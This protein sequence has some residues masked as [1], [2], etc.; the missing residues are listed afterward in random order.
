MTGSNQD[1]SQTHLLKETDLR[2]EDSIQRSYK[3]GKMTSK[4]KLLRIRDR[5][6][7]LP[8]RTAQT[9]LKFLAKSKL[10]NLLLAQVN[11]ITGRTHQI[12]VHL[13]HHGLPILG[14][15]LYDKKVEKKDDKKVE[16]KDVW[17]PTR[18]LLHSLRLELDH[19][20]SQKRMRFEAPLQEDMLQILRL[21]FNWKV[22]PVG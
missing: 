10:H 8:R 20:I 14:D 22:W 7:C 1:D 5:Y 2:I 11:I 18:A 12:R 4:K 16:K 21:F 6:P 17:F 3:T 13:S 19:P 9:R 15:Q